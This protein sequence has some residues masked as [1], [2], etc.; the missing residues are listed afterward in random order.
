MFSSKLLNRNKI[1]N[2]STKGIKISSNTILLTYHEINCGALK[3]FAYKQILKVFNV[4][5]KTLVSCFIIYI[6][7]FLYMQLINFG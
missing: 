3:L 1:S 4:V 5:T 6:I 2:I 7:I